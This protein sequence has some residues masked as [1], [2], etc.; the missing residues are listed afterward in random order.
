VIDLVRRDNGWTGGQ[1]SVV[2]AL[3]GL[4]L[5]WH[6]VAL[7]PYGAELF[8]SAGVLPNASLSP[9]LRAF[10]NLL[11]LDDSPASVVLLLAIGVVLSVAFTTG[12]RDRLAAVAL[13]YLWACLF[14]RN[15]LISNPSIPYIGWLLLAHAALPAAPFGSF[16]ARGRIDPGG[17]WFFPRPLFLV[18]WIALAV[19]YSYSGY[20]KLVSPSWLDG[21]AMRKVVENPLARPTVVQSALLSLPPELLHLPTYAALALELLFL[22]LAVITR[23][24]PWLW[25]TLFTMHAGLIVL[26]DFAD[27][28]VA[29]LL[30]HLFTFE[31]AW[32]PRR[33]GPAPERL[34]YDGQCG[35]CHG[36]VRLLLAEDRDGS[37]FRFSP[38]GGDIF[39]REVPEARRRTLPDGVVVQRA[40]GSILVRSAAILHALHALG[41]LWRVL[42]ALLGVIPLAALDVAYRGV[43]RVRHRLFRRPDNACPLMPPALRKRFEL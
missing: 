18:A 42:A 7:L 10:P 41:G 20:T 32:I 4:Y 31:P 29:M 6:F 9:L 38:L 13:W 27:L 21:S 15:P 40:D 11:S 5:L 39:E 1:Y 37:A 2:R 12:Y 16:S 33:V 30:F 3:V 23:V 26:I 14:G 43:A 36:T 19:G 24:R 17:G 8:S 25:A 28:S 34:F 22:P 35:L